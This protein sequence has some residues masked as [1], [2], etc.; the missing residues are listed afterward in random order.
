MA[1][2]ARPETVSGAQLE[3]WHNLSKRDELVA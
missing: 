1:D 2:W 3:K